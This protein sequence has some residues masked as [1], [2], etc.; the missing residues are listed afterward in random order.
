MEGNCSK[1]ASCSSTLAIKLEKKT[2]W[3]GNAGYTSRRKTLKKKGER[4]LLTI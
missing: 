3:I 1:D 4:K 2:N